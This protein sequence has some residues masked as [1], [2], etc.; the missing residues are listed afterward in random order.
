MAENSLR[1]KYLYKVV[2]YLI[3]VTPI[4]IS[5]AYLLNTIL[6]YFYMD[7]PIIS[8]LT[9]VSL[10]TILFLYATSITFRFCFYHRIFIHYISLNWILD[11]IDYNIGILI[12]NRS[13]FLVY[14][15]ITGIFLLIILY[16]H[17]RKRN[18]K[19][20]KRNS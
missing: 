9:G 16:E 14:I 6:S 18:I 13:L 10:V 3:K 15:I 19:I 20:I 5:V 2:L 17:C 4:V 11:V 7:L 12:S 1:S 8:Y